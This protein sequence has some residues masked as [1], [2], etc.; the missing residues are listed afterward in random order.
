MKTI[1]RACCRGEV[2]ALNVKRGSALVAK[3]GVLRMEYR[4]QSLDWLLDAALYRYVKLDDGA[5]HVFPCDAFVK[6]QSDGA[7]TVICVIMHPRPVISRVLSRLNVVRA[8]RR[9]PSR[10]AS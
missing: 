6:V 5:Q 2:L 8:W 4:D 9:M 7:H 1:E 3:D 10:V